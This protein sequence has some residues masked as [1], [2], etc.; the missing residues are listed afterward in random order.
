[1]V[2]TMTVFFVVGGDENGYARIEAG[3]GLAVRLDDAVDEREETDDDEARAHENV[4]EEED[5]DDEVADNVERGEGDG[6]G[7]GAA[8]AARR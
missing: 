2:R 3:R 5:E 1:M 6:V 7:D 8:R 4:A